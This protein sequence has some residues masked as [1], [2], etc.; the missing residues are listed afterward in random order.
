[1]ADPSSR[2]V[3]SAT[4]TPAPD[5]HHVRVNVCSRE[6]AD[7]IAHGTSAAFTSMLGVARET[8]AAIPL[9]YESIEPHCAL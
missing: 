3:E 8:E 4:L 9:R 7:V 2:R 6:V 5:S 1:M